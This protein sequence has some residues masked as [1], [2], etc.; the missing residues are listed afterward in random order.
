MGQGLSL[1]SGCSGAPSHDE[2]G[3]GGMWAAQDLCPWSFYQRHGRAWTPRGW[4]CHV[5]YL[6]GFLGALGGLGDGI[7]SHV[8]YLCIFLDV[9]LPKHLFMQWPEAGGEWRK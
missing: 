7:L 2:G 8:Q 5:Q 6:E 9:Y 4:E 3:V 1:S